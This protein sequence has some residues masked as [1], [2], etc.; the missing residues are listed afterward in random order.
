MYLFPRLL[1]V[2]TFVVIL[3]IVCWAIKSLRDVSTKTILKIYLVLL[4]L[5]AF[6]FIPHEGSDLS[7]LLPI[8]HGYANLEFGTL[9]EIMQEYP[10]PGMLLI[11]YIL[12]NIGIDG[13]L[14]MFGTF[15]TYSCVFYIIIDASKRFQINKKNIALVLFWYMSLGAFGFVIGNVKTVMSVAI[16]ALAYYKE[17]IE[18]NSFIKTFPI[19][20][21]GASIDRKSV[22]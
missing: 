6:F 11:Y 7:R 5:M 15:V 16:V 13:L 18:S 17:M 8:M 12:G 20:L 19:Y 3:F 22:V 10:S 14:P 2:G 21:I 9:L 4:C 1:G